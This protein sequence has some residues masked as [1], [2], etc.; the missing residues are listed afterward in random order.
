MRLDFCGHLDDVAF[1]VFSNSLPALKR[2]ELLG[3]FLVRPPGWQEFFKTHPKLEGFLITQSP[4]F[5]EDCIKALVKCCPD[6]KD[7]RLKEVG[8]LDDSFLNQIKL[9]KRGL[10]YLDLSD[11]SHSCTEKAMIALIRAVGKTL[12]HLNV[13]GH[14]DLA[15]TFLAKGLLP[16]VKSL[17]ALVLSHLPELTDDGVSKFFSDWTNAALVSL[18]ISRN[19]VLTGVSLNSILDHSGGRLEELNINGLKDIDQDALRKIGQT[20]PA[21]KKLNVG[22]CRFVDDFI[23]QAW[24]AGEVSGGT[25][26]AGCSHLEELKVWG[27]NRVTNCCPKKV[28]A[29]CIIFSNAVSDDPCRRVLPSSVWNSTERVKFFCEIQISYTFRRIPI[30]LGLQNIPLLSERRQAKSS[31]SFSQGESGLRYSRDYFSFKSRS[32]CLI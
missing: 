18:D 22:F 21:L 6:I 13:S 27:C 11:P 20:S 23:I 26:T 29:W 8:K 15:D 3:P 5:D 12:T 4:R 1:K 16:H 14:A 30:F 28:R 7:L 32:V 31:F 17:E 9:L 2:I 10:R 24:L 25:R 19:D